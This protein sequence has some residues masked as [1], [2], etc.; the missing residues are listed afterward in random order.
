LTEKKIYN[1]KNKKR[2]KQEINNGGK[3]INVSKSI[4]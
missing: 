4:K 3:R 2:K 1:I